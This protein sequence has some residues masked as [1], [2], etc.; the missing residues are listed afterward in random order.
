LRDEQIE[1]EK[2][3]QRSDKLEVSGGNDVAR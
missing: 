2:R 3:R 1:S